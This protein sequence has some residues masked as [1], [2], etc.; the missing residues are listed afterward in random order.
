MRQTKSPHVARGLWIIPIHESLHILVDPVTRGCGEKSTGRV[1]TNS[2]FTTRRK[3]SL[4]IQLNGS[5]QTHEIVICF[6]INNNIF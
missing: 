4:P 1:A 3:Q 2:L 6:L 5:I